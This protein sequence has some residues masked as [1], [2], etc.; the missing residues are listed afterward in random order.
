[1]LGLYD[2]VETLLGSV[3]P[4]GVIRFIDGLQQDSSGHASVVAFV[5]EFF[6]ALWA[7]SGAA[8]AVIKAV[9]RAY[10]LDDPW[11]VWKLRLIARA[12]RRDD[13]VHDDRHARARRLWRPA[14]RGDRGTRRTCE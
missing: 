2:D 9:N 10:G 14:G 11:P 5:V 13:G 8:G 6:G 1:M 3:P 7:A 12:A 4:S